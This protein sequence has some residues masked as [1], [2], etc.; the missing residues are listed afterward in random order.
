MERIRNLILAII[1]FLPVGVFAQY[2]KYKIQGMLGAYNSPA[3]VYLQASVGGRTIMDSVTLKEGKFQF[4]GRV[5]DIPVRAYLILNP[6]GTGPNTNDAKPIYIEKGVTT[7]TGNDL[8]T[9]AKVEG[10]KTN[11]ENEKFQMAY[12]P[13]NDDQQAIVDKEMAATPEQL[14]SPEFIKQDKMAQKAV[15]EQ[16]VAVNKKFIKDYPDSY[17]SLDLLEAYSYIADYADLAPLYDSLSDA[18]KQSVDGKTFAARLSKLKVVALGALAPEFVEPD[19][20]GKM[21]SLSSFKGKYVLLDFWAS[22]CGPCRQEN[23]NLVRAYSRFKGKNFTVFGVSLDR[24]GTKSSWLKAIHDDGLLWTQVSELK[25]AYGKAA[26]LY[27]VQVIPQ[28]FLLDP[29]GRI[30]GHNLMGDDLQDKLTE[31]FG[32][33]DATSDGSK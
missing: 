14:Q 20:S 9:N 26:T 2:E 8:V 19:T 16:T 10:T 31:L 12:K 25:F 33:G 22:W 1:V 24:P 23:P 29:E 27:G 6:K 11:E 13:I 28:N 3:K 7:V 17:I 5:G 15:N 21:V 30:I 18:L 4:S 32:K